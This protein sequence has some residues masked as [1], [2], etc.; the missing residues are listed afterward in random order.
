[1]KVGLLGGTA[2]YWTLGKGCQ[3]VGRFFVWGEIRGWH[4][5][6]P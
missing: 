4:P 2:Q 5:A 6:V 1:M 3:E